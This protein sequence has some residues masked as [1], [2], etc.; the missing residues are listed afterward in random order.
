MLL[1]LE[2]WFRNHGYKGMEF[3]TSFGS[4]AFKFHDCILIGFRMATSS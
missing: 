3:G 2:R 4:S 1:E